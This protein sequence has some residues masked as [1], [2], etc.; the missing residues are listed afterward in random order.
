MF[1]T[2]VENVNLPNGVTLTIRSWAIGPFHRH[3]EI[4][5]EDANGKSKVYRGGSGIGSGCVFNG[6]GEFDVNNS[7]D[8]PVK[9]EWSMGFPW[10]LSTMSV[11]YNGAKVWKW[12][13]HPFGRAHSEY[14][15][16]PKA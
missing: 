11:S 1:I 5:A 4:E 10:W 16:Y 8:Q 12:S 13:G 2:I 7:T 3:I 9:F 15:E 14:V 6:D